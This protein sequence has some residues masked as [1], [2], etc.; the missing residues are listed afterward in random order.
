MMYHEQ[1][2]AFCFLSK[3]KIILRLKVKAKLQ[4]EGRPGNFSALILNT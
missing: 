1:H 3:S 2:K 4:Q